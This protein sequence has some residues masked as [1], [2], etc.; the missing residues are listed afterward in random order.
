VADLPARHRFLFVKVKIDGHFLA[1]TLT[2][3]QDVC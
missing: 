2:L 3:S 1:S